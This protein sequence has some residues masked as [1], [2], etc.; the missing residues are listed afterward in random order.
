VLVGITWNTQIFW[1]GVSS[2]L[3]QA[4]IYILVGLSYS[5]I[6]AASGIFNFA[7]GTV[8]TIGAVAAYVLGVTYGLPVAEVVACVV[9]GGVVIG[10]VSHFL[11]A[12][13][14]MGTGTS[15]TEEA[16]VSTLGL[17]MAGAALVEKLFG[18]DTQPVPSYFTNTPVVIIGGIAVDPSYFLMA[19]VA[20]IAAILLDQMMMRTSVGLAWRAGIQDAEGASLFGI[21]QRKLVLG[22]F[23]VGCALA[24]VAGFLFA[25]ITSASAFVGSNVSVYGFAA[26]AL[27][28]YGSFRG[29][30]VGGIIVGLVSGLSQAFFNPNLSEPLIFAVLIVVL[31]IRPQGLFGTAGQFGASRVRVV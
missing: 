25:P 5:V 29:T 16:L 26:M 22:A 14:F 19:G 21:D 1:L 8:I 6:L 30:L 18:P 20:V 12:R 31:L 4:G 27:G 15:L 23:C 13:P 9:A 28:G 24:A 17:G 11:A 7:Q 2:G 10:G 3:G